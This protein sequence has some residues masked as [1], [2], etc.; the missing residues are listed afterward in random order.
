MCGSVNIAEEVT[1]EVFLVLVTSGSRFDPSRGPL[2]PYLYG[3]ARIQDCT[4]GLVEP[5]EAFTR[6]LREGEAS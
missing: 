3:L 2:L 5:S 1:Q 6:P 4:L